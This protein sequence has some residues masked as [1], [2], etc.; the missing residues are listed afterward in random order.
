MPIQP[1]L[2][3][4]P[5][6]WSDLRGRVARD[7]GFENIVPYLVRRRAAATKDSID[8]ALACEHL[9][10]RFEG[11]IECFGDFLGLLSAGL[12]HVRGGGGPAC[13]GHSDA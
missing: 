11:G 13:E 9:A 6:Y 10:G 4:N 12:G 2:V 7:R 8:G 5:G 3:N 1:Q